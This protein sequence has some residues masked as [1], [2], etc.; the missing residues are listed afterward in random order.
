MLSFETS[1]RA[2]ELTDDEL[3]VF[4]WLG[5]TKTN[6]EIGVILGV[7]TGTVKKHVGQI[8]AKLGFENRTA[9]ARCAWEMGI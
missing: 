8:L 2:P 5:E 6:P 9:A 1:A 7:A 3:A 4:H